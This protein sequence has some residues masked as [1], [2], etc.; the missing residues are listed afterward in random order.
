MRPGGPMEV[1]EP[2]PIS[3]AT[4]DGLAAFAPPR[5]G[6]SIVGHPSTKVQVYIYICGVKE[7]SFQFP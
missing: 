7:V 3:Q 4:G 5:I 2:G 1:L 6:T